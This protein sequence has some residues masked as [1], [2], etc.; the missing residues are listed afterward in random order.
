MISTRLIA[1]L[2]GSLLFLGRGAS[3]E[4]ADCRAKLKA[5]DERCQ[6]LAEKRAAA[7]PGGDASQSPG[8]KQLSSQI[9]STCTR[10]PCAPPRRTKRKKGMGMSPG[11][12][13]AAPKKS[14]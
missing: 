9:A 14:E 1:L 4:T 5:Q 8:C 11:T 7:C 6:I 3:A 12:G 13:M 10:R 2:V